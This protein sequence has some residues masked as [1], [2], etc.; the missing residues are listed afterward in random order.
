MNLSKEEMINKLVDGVDEWDINNL[1]E[2]VKTELRHKLE[3]S[4]EKEVY[5]E[6]KMQMDGEIV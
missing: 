2:W 1:I 6:Y 5:K 3:E 4:T